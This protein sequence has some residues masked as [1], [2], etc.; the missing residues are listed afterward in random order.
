[1]S[2]RIKPVAAPLR[3]Q[4][5]ERLRDAIAEGE[6]RPGERL[7]ERELCESLGVS[8]TSVREALRQLE[9]EGLID[10]IPNK[11][12]V[13][14]TVTPETAAEIY[15]VRAA[16][17]ALAAEAFTRHANA[18]HKQALKAS[19]RKLEAALKGNDLSAQLAAKRDFYDALLEGAGNR[20]AAQMLERLNAQI[21]QLRATSLARPGR[22][23]KSLAELKAIMTHALRG[24]GSAAA[25]ACRA[26]VL[27]ASKLAIA[28]LREQ[29]SG[30]G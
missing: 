20:T 10:T 21:R 28:A 2:L 8:R 26:H 17:E 23:R 18:H 11:G 24:D 7:R 6:L 22:S 29:D 30:E 12:V 25:D 13:V 27:N 15:A 4:V 16:L 9:S 5:K 14:A 1:M 3:E 19:Y